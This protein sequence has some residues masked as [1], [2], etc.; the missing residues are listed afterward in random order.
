MAA[1]PAAVGLVAS[2][3][4]HVAAQHVTPGKCPL[5]HLAQI[6]FRVRVCTVSGPGLVSAGHVLGESVVKAESL[7]TQRTQ[8]LGP[9]WTGG[10][11]GHPL[12][13]RRGQADLVSSCYLGAGL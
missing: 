11:Q 4:P 1:H 13:Q 12:R 6:R 8:P 10:V 2:V 5:A 9:A 3:E 7:V